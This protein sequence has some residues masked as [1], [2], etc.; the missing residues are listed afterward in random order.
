M[1]E[2]KLANLIEILRITLSRGDEFVTATDLAQILTILLHQVIE[3]DK[4]SEAI[5]ILDKEQS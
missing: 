2:N 4:I 1:R 3:N 5:D